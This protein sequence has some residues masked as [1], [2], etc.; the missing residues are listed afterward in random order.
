MTPN[1]TDILPSKSSV[2]SFL[3]FSVEPL[4]L[5]M[6]QFMCGY[7]HVHAS[8][9][10]RAPTHTR[11]HASFDREILIARSRSSLKLA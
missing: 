4:L 3:I 11:V 9:C 2:K 10:T 7:E 6:L 8:M 1:G 5:D